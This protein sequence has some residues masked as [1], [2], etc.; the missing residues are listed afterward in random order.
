MF[1]QAKKAVYV[2]LDQIRNLNIPIDLK[3]YSL[4]TLFHL[5]HYMVVRYWTLKTAQ[6]LNIYIMIFSDK[7]ISTPKYM[8]HDVLYKSMSSHE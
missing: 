8:L 3:F 6:L 7:I 5:F 4:A 2:L 1:E